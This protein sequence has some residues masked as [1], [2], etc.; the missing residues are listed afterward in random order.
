MANRPHLLVILAGISGSGKSFLTSALAQKRGF[1]IIPSL[2]TRQ[3]RPGEGTALDRRF[4]SQQEFD[5][6]QGRNQVICGRFFFGSWYGLDIECI[7]ATRARG[8]AVVQLTYKS[9]EKLWGRYPDAKAVYVL[10]PSIQAAKDSVTSRGLAA[11][12]TAERLREI[13]DE[14]A[15]VAADRQKAIPLFDAYFENTRAPNTSGDFIALIDRLA[16]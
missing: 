6:L 10:A 12:E 14:S 5:H 9:I 4:C 7:D 15:F 2:T 8:N 1:G 16:L 3:P 11:E 13:D